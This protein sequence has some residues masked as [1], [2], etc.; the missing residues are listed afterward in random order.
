M[1]EEYKPVMKMLG[2]TFLNESD[3][4][5][6]DRP[7]H[8]LETGRQYAL[9]PLPD[10]TYPL[11]VRY[12]IDLQKLDVASTA[13]TDLLRTWRSLYHQGIFVKTLRDED[14][15]RKDIEFAIYQGMISRVTGKSSQSGFITPHEA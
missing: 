11:L 2:D 14:D 9:F 1:A 5:M 12:W 10:K 8:Y 7:K 4:T 15:A 6:R 3:R 13:F